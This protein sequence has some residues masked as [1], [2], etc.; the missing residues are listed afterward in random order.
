MA[1]TVPLREIRQGGQLLRIQTPSQH[2]RSHGTQPILLLPPHPDVIPALGRL[3]DA[4]HRLVTLT[5]SSKAAVA[6]GLAKKLGIEKTLYPVQNTRGK[7][8]KKSMIHNDATPNIEVDPETYLV[9]ADGV[10]L[11]CE[12]AK[13]LP[14]AQRYFL[15]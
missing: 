13:V 1:I 5:N 8:S 15:F 4:G 6:S 2:G 12:P 10:P 14:M 3:R 11:I 9:R 7:I